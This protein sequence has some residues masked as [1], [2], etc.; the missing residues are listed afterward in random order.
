MDSIPQPPAAGNTSPAEWLGNLFSAITQ[1]LFDS[2][3]Q[4]QFAKALQAKVGFAGDGSMF[5]PI[6]PALSDRLGVISPWDILAELRP[7]LSAAS[8]LDF[9]C[10]EAPYLEFLQKHGYQWHGLDVADSLDQGSIRAAETFKQN[11]AVTFYD[12]GAIPLAS[13]SYD[14]VLSIQ[15]LEHVHDPHLSISEIARI[16]KP[17]GFLVGSVSH[18]EAYHAYSTFNYTPYGFKILC[19]RHGLVVELLHATIDGPMLV[20]R[21]IAI[22]AGYQ[23][24]LKQIDG[25]AWSKL[26]PLSKVF[27]TMG[28]NAKVSPQ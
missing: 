6:K 11:P 8:L 19:E 14:V 26:T 24:A 18:L 20:L 17:G 16:L 21:Q 1:G 9:G 15:S 27:E 13:N 23:D 4:E 28:Q 25:L 22:I 5:K 12:G 3:Q 2:S 10:G 7:R